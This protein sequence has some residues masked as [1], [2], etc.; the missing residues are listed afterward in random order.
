MSIFSNFEQG[1]TTLQGEEG[2][3]SQHHQTGE[4]GHQNP[5]GRLLLSST[6]SRQRGSFGSH[7]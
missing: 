6:H 1:P 7:G 2:A 5:Q 3:G 4:G